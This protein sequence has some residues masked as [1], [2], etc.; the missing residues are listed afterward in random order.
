MRRRPPLGGRR[1]GSSQRADDDSS[2]RLADIPDRA[3]GREVTACRSIKLPGADR[4]R[5]KSLRSFHTNCKGFCS[6]M[7]TRLSTRQRGL[8]GFC[9]ISWPSFSGS[10]SWRASSAAP[11]RRDKHL[12]RLLVPPR[13]QRQSPSRLR[14]RLRRRLLLRLLLRLRLRRLLRLRLLLLLCRRHALRHR[15]LLLPSRL[16]LHL[17]RQRLRGTR[18]PPPSVPV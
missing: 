9:G 10:P 8:E 1:A 4:P 16:R 11:S 17:R 3:G 2:M 12:I 15:P 14:R 6:R 13:T 7:A 5:D 18:L